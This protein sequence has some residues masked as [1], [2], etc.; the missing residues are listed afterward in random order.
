MFLDR[1]GK[2]DAGPFQK[3]IVED[4]PDR[5]LPYLDFTRLPR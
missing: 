5:G 1:L 3:V 4:A 2:F